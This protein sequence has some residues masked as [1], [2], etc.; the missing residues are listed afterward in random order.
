MTIQKRKLTPGKV[1]AQAPVA[2][3]SPLDIARDAWGD[4]V[5]DW[6]EVLATQ[7][8]ETSQAK[9]ASRIGYSG[10]M[11]SQL[12]R[13]KYKGDVGAVETAVRGAWMGA[14]VTCPALGTL[15][16]DICMDWQKK[17]K[18]FVPSNSHRARMFRACRS[19]PVC[20]GVGEDS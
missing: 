13:A 7:C 3:S 5:P 17:A 9:V 10:S 16:T 15:P 1:Q 8:M 4:P 6:I 12:L 20:T 11:V 14:T 2:A 19:C 18:K